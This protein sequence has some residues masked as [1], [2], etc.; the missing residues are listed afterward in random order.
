MRLAG[1][2]VGLDVLGATEDLESR[3]A[4]DAVGLAEVLLLGAVD[5]GELDLLVFEGGGRF[6]VL[7]GEGLA[8]AA[9]W[10]EDCVEGEG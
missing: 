5:L 4:L 6:L 3:V 7:G 9:P 2:G 8:V 10:R 1:A